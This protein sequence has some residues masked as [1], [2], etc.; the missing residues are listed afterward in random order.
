L[1]QKSKLIGEQIMIVFGRDIGGAAVLR[2]FFS[3]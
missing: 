3:F 2:N 1:S